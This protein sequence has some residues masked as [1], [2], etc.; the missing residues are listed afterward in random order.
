L[1]TG[2]SPVRPTIFGKAV[3][4][5]DL[6]KSAAGRR[7][8]LVETPQNTVWHC[9]YCSRDYQTE[10]GFMNHHCRE[11][12]KLDELRSPLGQSAYL[13]YSA[14]LRYKKRSVP[15][16]ETF[17]A[18][19]QY[20]YFIKFAEWAAKTAIP[21]IDRFIELMVETD[22][23]P[24]LWC[25]NTTFALYLQWYDSTYPPEFQFI[26]TL[27]F[28]KITA[29]DYACDLRDVFSTLGYTA[30]AKLVRRRK[31][32][33]WLLVVSPVFLRWAQSLSQEKR[34][35]LN[36]AIDFRTYADKIKERPELAAE[37]RT[38]CQQEG[39]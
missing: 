3:N 39:L 35:I 26:E 2:S 29:S 32:S 6:R 37:L 16:A 36:E 7:N 9:E 22:T 11:R 28:L 20:N 34:D 31:I 13:H 30:I 12:E 19:R 14:W 8:S 38:A 1:V 18:S 23:P 27:D 24:M 15:P 4:R 33:P 25:R 10:N 5:E 17:M 21:N